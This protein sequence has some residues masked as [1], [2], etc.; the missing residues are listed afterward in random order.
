MRVAITGGMGAGKS[1][2]SRLLAAR[3]YLVIDADSRTHQLYAENSELRRDLARAF[4]SEILTPEGV[5]RPR[6]GQLVF[7]NSKALALLE[8]LVHPCLLQVLEQ[9]IKQGEEKGIVFLEGAVLPRWQD[10]LA[11]FSAIILVTAPDDLRRQRL[12]TRGMHPQD[13]QKRLQEQSRF[14]PLCHPCIL[15]LENDGLPAELEPAIDKILR[16]IQKPS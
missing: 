9:E 8:S 10:W 7:G 1:T 2:V 3:G 11:T 15:M 13:I 14:P 12:Q 6:L 5:D 4:G 16:K